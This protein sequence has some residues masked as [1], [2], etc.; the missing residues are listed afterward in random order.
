MVGTTITFSPATAEN[1]VQV[2]KIVILTLDSSGNLIKINQVDTVKAPYYPAS[3][4]ISPSGDWIY[5]D[6]R[7]LC[8]SANLDASL[9]RRHISMYPNFWG[10]NILF[11]TRNKNNYK[12]RDFDMSIRLY[13]GG[14]G[15]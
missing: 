12:I 14:W 4:D 8:C 9:F 7:R 11:A 5:F 10:R 3:I 1:Y 6:K 2:N 13:S 15:E